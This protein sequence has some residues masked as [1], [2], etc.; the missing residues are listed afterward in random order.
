LLVLL[1]AEQTFSQVPLSQVQRAEVYIIHNPIQSKFNYLILKFFTK[2]NSILSHSFV[3]QIEQ[4]TQFGQYS[5]EK[6]VD[7]YF[8]LIDPNMQIDTSLIIKEHGL[9]R[10]MLWNLHA[11]Q[12]APDHRYFNLADSLIQGGNA[13]DLTH[14]GIF[15]GFVN[16]QVPGSKSPQILSL[17]KTTMLALR[18]IYRKLAFDQDTWLEAIIGMQL[19]QKSK[20]LNPASLKKILSNQRADGGWSFT[21]ESGE[22]SNEHTTVLAL[23][24]LNNY[25]YYRHD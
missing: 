10:W 3:N 23:W 25:F 20:I 24:V 8:K 4:C 13:R 7:Q 11:D 16:Q 12:L 19:I 21:L 18:K 22:Q 17:K 15:L 2:N 9:Q 14:I 5:D 6:N 1:L